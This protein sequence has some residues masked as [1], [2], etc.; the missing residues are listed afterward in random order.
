MRAWRVA[1]ALHDIPSC[2]S[3]TNHISIIQHQCIKNLTAVLEA[4]GSSIDK[5]VEVNVFLADMAD[6]V[7]MNDVYKTYFGD[8]KPART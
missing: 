4:A 1:R 5:A 6:F 8:V 2:D 3:D 7:A